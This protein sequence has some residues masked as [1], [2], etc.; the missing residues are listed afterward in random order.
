MELSDYG[1]RYY[2]NGICDEWKRKSPEYYGVVRTLV[3]QKT[4]LFLCKVEYC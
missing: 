4:V 3:V 2:W 1:S